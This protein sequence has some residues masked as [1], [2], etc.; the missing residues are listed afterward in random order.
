MRFWHLGSIPPGVHYDE[1]YNGMN[2]LWANQAHDWKIFYEEN[3]GREGLHINVI[4]FF[5][6][7]FGNNTVGLRTANAMWGSL[8]IIGFFLLLRELRF[9]KLSVAV[10]TFMIVTS[11]WHLVFSRT[12]YRAIMVP[13]VL[14]FLFLFL[15]KGIYR[16]EHRTRNFII[17]GLFMGLGFNTYIAFRIAPIIVLIVA[18]SFIFFRRDFFRKHWKVSLAFVMSAVL[19]ALPI[20]I[21]FSDHVKDFIS[22]SEAVSIFNAP[23][24]TLWQAFW[25]SLGT[26]I[27]AFFVLG[28]KNPRHNFMSQPLLPAAWSVLFAIGF[29]ISLKE[30][31]STVINKIQ[32]KERITTRWF[33]VSVLAQ[34]I[35]WVMLVPG[36]MSIEGI[37]HSLR[38]IGVIPAV[39]ILSLLPFEY[40]L[41]LYEEIKNSPNL[42]SKPWQKNRFITIFSGLVLMV[43]FGGASQVYIYFNNWANDVATL[44]AYE[45]KLYDFGLLIKDLS[46]KK[47]NYVIGAY[48]TFI[49]PDRRQSS[50]KTSEFIGYPNSQKYVFYRQMDGIGQTSCDDP[51]LV[52]LESD[53]WLRDQYRSVCP[54][55]KQKRYNYDNGKYS[56]WVMS[57]NP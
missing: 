54:D 7:I 23:N 20:L 44:G 1:A 26:H 33:F 45:R 46:L 37:P 29:L 4:A 35:F 11:F 40:I 24:L 53:Q 31:V 12:A 6:S 32:K 42:A 47:N 43:V 28:D 5:I 21:F 16:K 39:F 49:S 36:V 57:N 30:I 9:S 34:S 14:I 2:A 15:W 10:G 8:T 52:F 22:R 50:L 41:N 17:S 3:T 38:I 48:N 19:S 27:W 18:L 56:F 55:L 25:K 51:L 13:F